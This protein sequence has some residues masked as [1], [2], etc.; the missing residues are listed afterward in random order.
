MPTIRRFL[1]RLVQALLLLLEVPPFLRSTAVVRLLLAPCACHGF[2]QPYWK[3]GPN[4]PL[5]PSFTVIAIIVQGM[6]HAL[7]C[8]R[9]GRDEARCTLNCRHL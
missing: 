3:I 9:R 8:N 4:A 7:Q 2:Q 5:Y 6:K 1:D